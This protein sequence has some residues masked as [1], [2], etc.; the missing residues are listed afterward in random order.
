[1]TRDQALAYVQ[2]VLSPIITA[3]GRGADDTV[4]GLGLALDR[5]F[6]IYIAA[7]GLT[8]TVTT[9]T[10]PDADLECFLALLEATTY[11]LLIPALSA[12]QVDFSI[13]A[14][15]TTIKQSQAFKQYQS[16]ANNAWS[17]ASVCGYGFDLDNTNAFR[18]NLDFNE[19]SM[20]GNE[21]G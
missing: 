9:T 2:S 16:L 19:P 17:R 15:L 5:A 4:P 20:T 21:W 13:D 1:M 12:T 7:N 14:P 11:D 3:S 6:R 18:I 10:V 8:T